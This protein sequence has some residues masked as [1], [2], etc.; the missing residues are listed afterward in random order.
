MIERSR[1]WVVRSGEEGPLHAIVARA[2]GDAAAITEGRVFVG[3]RRAG[4]ADEPVAVGDEVAI[5]PARNA[6]VEATVL[7]HEDDLVAADKPA[8]MPTIAD[9]S[10]AAHTLVAAVA[11]TLCVDP[12]RLHA[13]SRLDRD[14]SGV[15]VF[16]L[17]A[18]AGERLRRA[19]EA[20]AYVR[21]YVAI[22]SRT[23][24]PDCG[25]WDTPIGRAQD[26]RKRAPMGRDATDARSRFATVA[27]TPMGTLLAL[28]PGTG[29]THQLRVHASHAGAALL[30]DRDYGGPTRLTLAEGRV[31]GIRRIALHA[32]RVTVPRSVGAPLVVD[33]PVP[34]E[35]VDLWEVLGGSGLDWRQAVELP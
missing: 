35:L 10:G 31:V 1:R 23:P 26:P 25:V 17:T 19:R 2:G 13:T 5:A 9:H 21:R 8:G 3:R 4:S 12:G 16:A 18:D 7:A 20:G 34:D 27:K 28:S 32:S 22:A 6:T 14:V 15:V 11:R 24:T 33:S 30:G 29:R